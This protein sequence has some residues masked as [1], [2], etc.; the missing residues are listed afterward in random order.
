MPPRPSKRVTLTVLDDD[1]CLSGLYG[2]AIIGS[3]SAA[4]GMTSVTSAPTSSDKTITSTVDTYITVPCSDDTDIGA[5]TTT[6]SKHTTST[7]LI[8]VTITSSR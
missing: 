6:V 3:S 7:D 1:G 2:R 5:S 8:T 4:V